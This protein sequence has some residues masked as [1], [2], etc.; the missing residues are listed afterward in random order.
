MSRPFAISSAHPFLF[1]AVSVAISGCGSFPLVFVEESKIAIS[2]AARANSPEPIQVTAGFKE[3]VYA[4]VPPNGF[5]PQG[6][7]AATDAQSLLADFDVAYKRS[8]LSVGVTHGLASG[9]AAQ[10]L[11]ESGLATLAFFSRGPVPT[12]VQDRRVHAIRFVNGLDAEALKAA[13]LAVKIPR[14][15][16]LDEKLRREEILKRLL[17]VRTEG[18]IEEIEKQ[19]EVAFP[20]RF[21]RGSAARPGNP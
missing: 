13:S 14:T 12:A 18:Q 1:I 19:L 4:V 6:T 20:E 5:Q 17:A 10:E 15:E 7:P 11:S 9:A 21:K 16:S 3:V 8:N 2:I